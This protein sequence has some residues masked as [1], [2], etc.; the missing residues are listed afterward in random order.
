MNVRYSGLT[1]ALPRSNFVCETYVILCIVKFLLFSFDCSILEDFLGFLV[2]DFVCYNARSDYPIPFL[3]IF[4]LRIFISPDSCTMYMEKKTNI[5]WT[6][7][8][9][10][11]MIPLLFTTEDRQ[12]PILVCRVW[13]NCSR[14][15]HYEKVQFFSGNNH[16]LVTPQRSNH[17]KQKIIVHQAST[18]KNVPIPIV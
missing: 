3:A 4:L 15:S 2:M 14:S 13:R 10:L 12:M 1:L 18:V 11:L 17:V 6:Q 8:T 9:R 5:H 16:G 7:I